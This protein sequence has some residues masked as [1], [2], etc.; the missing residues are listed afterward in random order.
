MQH[1]NLLERSGG[2]IY[3]AHQVRH[4]SGKAGFQSVGESWIQRA[5]HL[6]PPTVF[7]FDLL[8]ETNISK[9]KKI[10]KTKQYV[11]LI[12]ISDITPK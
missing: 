1:A 7:V 8:G 2:F 12:Y 9:K 11:S 10:V 5:G 4:L 3:L 6:L